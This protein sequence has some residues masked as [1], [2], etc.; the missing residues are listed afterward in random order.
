MTA[1]LPK[2]FLLRPATGEDLPAVVV[3]FNA[4]DRRFSGEDEHTEGGV[5]ENW[6]TLGFDLA[7]DACVVLDPTGRL[8][9]YEH[10]W[11]T[12]PPHV[13]LSLTGR[14][15]PEAMGKGIGTALVRWGEA[16]ASA[17]VPLAPEGSRVVL[18]ATLF[19]QDGAGRT[20]LLAEEFVAVRHSFRMAVDFGGPPPP[21]ALPEGIR[22]RPFAPGKDLEATVAA[23]GDAFRDHWG[24]VE[25]PFAFKVEQ[26]RR[27]MDTSSSFDPSLWFLALDGERIAGLILCQPSASDP[28]LAFVDTLAVRR[29]WRRHGLGLALLRHAF[30]ELYARGLRRA[31]LYVDAR[32]LT[33]ATRLYERAGMTVERRFDTWERGLRSGVDLTTQSTLPSD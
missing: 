2:G 24:F 13:R 30:A 32:S 21:P 18:R 19:E 11:D 16:R 28:A 6:A 14:V 33:G 25:R 7:R 31:A 5:R 15:H 26:W 1:P 4:C 27:W 17:S 29:P 23:E 20:L 12:A 10:V 3:L 8:V 9:G 22:V